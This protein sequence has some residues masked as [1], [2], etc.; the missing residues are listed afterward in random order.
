LSRINFF[1]GLSTKSKRCEES[2]LIMANISGKNPLQIQSLGSSSAGNCTV[3]W[4]EQSATI[5][6]FGFYP[7]II[8]ANLGKMGKKFSDLSGALITHTHTDH[9]N[10]FTLKILIENKVPIY[11]HEN[12]I[13]VIFRKFQTVL[14]PG[15]RNNFRPFNGEDFSIG[16]FEVHAFQVPHDSEGGCFG[17][18]IFRESIT[19]I[20]KISV[21]T[22]MGF[23][24]APL[25][26]EF[27]NS[28]VI[29]IESNH[30]T[31]MLEKSDRPWFL[32][33]RIKEIGHLSNV[34]CAQFL[35]DIFKSSDFLPDS[36][37]LAH[38]SQQCNTNALAESCIREALDSNNFTEIKVLQTF[39]NKPSK[40]IKIY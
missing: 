3:V 24:D 28:H 6:D 38:I 16:T 19:G 21:S 31:E 10:R 37:M 40:T 29:V 5:I 11:C 1:K 7:S 12:L 33:K 25:I 18:N 14:K 36:V 4:S 34:Q 17:Y 22:D 9:I 8:K 39:M 13:D 30:D 26:N 27:T 2:R 15:D 35:V 32:K 23:P 20:K